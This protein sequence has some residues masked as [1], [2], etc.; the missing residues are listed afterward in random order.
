MKYPKPSES[1]SHIF[2]EGNDVFLWPPEKC[3]PSDSSKPKENHPIILDD[4]EADKTAFSSETS[5]NFHVFFFGGFLGSFLFI[6]SGRPIAVKYLIMYEGRK[7]TA[8]LAYV[9]D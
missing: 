5:R 4:E 2:T 1:S 8:L 6:I 7:G 3:S 9:R